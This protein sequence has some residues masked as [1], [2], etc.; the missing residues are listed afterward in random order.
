MERERVDRVLDAIDELVD[1]SLAAGPVDNYNIDRYDR[2]PHC[3]RSWHGLPVTAYTAYIGAGEYDGTDDDSRILCHGSTFIGPMPPESTT[4]PPVCT[5][6]ITASSPK[7]S[8][9]PP[10]PPPLSR[11]GA[12]AANGNTQNTE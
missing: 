1:E 4:E 9:R 6:P 11:S 10:S 7:S 2:C 5:C 12:A 8:L 3:R